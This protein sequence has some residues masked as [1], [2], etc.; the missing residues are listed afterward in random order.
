MLGMMHV[1]RS[2]H[3]IIWCTGSARNLAKCDTSLVITS[4]GMKPVFIVVFSVPAQ[5]YSAF[6]A[7]MPYIT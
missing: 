4:Q 3:M 1:W 5:F 6:T 2:V 7:L